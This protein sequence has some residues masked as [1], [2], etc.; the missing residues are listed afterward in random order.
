LKKEN[1]SLFFFFFLRL[2][3]RL[4]RTNPRIVLNAPNDL[5]AIV[6]YDHEGTT[7]SS[8]EFGNHS[9][10]HSFK[11]FLLQDL[12]E[13]INGALVDTAGHRL[14]GLQHHTP[15]DGIEGVIERHDDSSSGGDGKERGDGADGALIGLIRIEVLDLLEETKLTSSIDEGAQHSHCPTCIESC[16]TLVPDRGP[17]AVPDA[18]ELALAFLQVRSETGTGKVERVTDRVRDGA[19]ETTA[20]EFRPDALPEVGLA[21]VI[22]EHFVQQIV[23]RQSGPLLGRVTETVNQ[24]ASPEGPE[25]LLRLDAGEAVDDGFVALDFAADHVRIG[26]LGLHQELHA[27]DG[28]HH[29]L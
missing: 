28:G 20:G 18:L 13:A 4:E 7:D 8:E 27:L 26:I 5:D 2:I 11:T 16:D 17:N 3:S 9:L 21:V 15:T 29:G 25:S 10:V 19:G 24:I 12:E 22:R 14:L 6:S 23:E 1:P